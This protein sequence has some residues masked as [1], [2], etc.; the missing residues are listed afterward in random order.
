MDALLLSA[1]VNE[2]ECHEKRGVALFPSMKTYIEAHLKLV[3]EFDGIPAQHLENLLYAAE[4][5]L[6]PYL[7]P[8]GQIAVQLNALIYKLSDK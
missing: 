2:Y 7:V 5:S 4:S 6:E 1:S 8:D 3:G